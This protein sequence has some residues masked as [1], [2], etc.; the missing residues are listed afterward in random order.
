M[1]VQHS[2]PGWESHDPSPTCWCEPR[3][4]MLRG[5]DILWDHDAKVCN[6]GRDHQFVEETGEC[7]RCGQT[8]PHAVVPNTVGWPL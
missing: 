4:V 6:D 7:L 5:G 3:A 8:Q 1:S 2:M